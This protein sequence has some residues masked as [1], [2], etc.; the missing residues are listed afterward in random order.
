M[1]T[2]FVGLSVRTLFSWILLLLWSILK[3]PLKALSDIDAGLVTS[4]APHNLS[5][6]DAL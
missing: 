4:I 2:P 6:W 1:I 5:F 3:I